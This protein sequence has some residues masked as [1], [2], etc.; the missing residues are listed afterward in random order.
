MTA[1][2]VYLKE[3]EYFE[4]G[5]FQWLVSLGPVFA[6]PIRRAQVRHTIPKRIEV[7]IDVSGRNLAPRMV[8]KPDSMPMQ[9]RPGKLHQVVMQGA[10][11]HSEMAQSFRLCVYDGPAP[12][13]TWRQ[14]EFEATYGSLEFTDD[15]KVAAETRAWFEKDG[16]QLG[17][18]SAH[19]ILT[20]KGEIEKTGDWSRVD[21][22]SV[23]LDVDT[24]AWKNKK[25]KE[26][27]DADRAERQAYNVKKAVDTGKNLASG[28][29]ETIGNIHR[30]MTS[31]AAEQKALESRKGSFHTAKNAMQI[32]SD[33][34][35]IMQKPIGQFRF[36]V[37]ADNEALEIQ[38]RCAW[39]EDLPAWPQAERELHCILNFEPE[40][41]GTTI[42]YDYFLYEVPPG[43][44]FANQLV[45]I[46][47]GWLK[48][49][50]A[51]I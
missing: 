7:E 51:S 8:F 45:R 18:Q 36:A 38:A 28:L 24:Q 2:K 23:K 43:S 35:K 25:A 49:L 27:A 32:F 6:A 48:A 1:T 42:H 41:F 47:N 10:V 13:K 17:R 40:E 12:L 37:N 31:E 19:F 50:S 21:E 16:H 5:R 15:I 44:I 29:V 26:I 22:P 30:E 9:T 14:L 11:E 4:P 34:Y 46:V 33:V 20:V 39:T 3:D